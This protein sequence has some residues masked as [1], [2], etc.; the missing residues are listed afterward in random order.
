MTIGGHCHPKFERVREEFE[1]NFAERDELGASVCVIVDGEAVVDLWGGIADQVSGR[2][3]DSDTVQVICSSTKGATALCGNML[4]DRGQL[5]PDRPVADYWPQFAKNGKETIPVRQVFN[6]Q[7][8]VF[9]WAPT[10]PDGGVCDWNLVVQA[11]EDTAPFWSPGTRQGYHGLSLGYLVGELVRRI[12]GRSIGTFFRD[13]VA[14]P[15]GLDF[16]IGLPGEIEPRV[17]STVVVDLA[18]VS[19]L[20]KDIGDRAPLAGHLFGNDGGWMSS[21]DR[22]AFHA[23]E[24]PAA[25]GITNG[26]GLASMYAPLSRDGSQGDVRLVSSAALGRMRTAQSVSDVDAVV[27]AR[28]SYTMG[29]SKSWH[30]PGLEAGPSVIIG[31]DAFGAPGMGGQMGFAD[32]SY[33]LAFGYTANRHGFGTGLNA[34]GQSLIDATYQVLGSPTC[35]PGFW[36]RPDRPRLC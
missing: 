10:L 20:I 18:T 13:E 33:Q 16:W 32:P 31:E 5:D 34:R 25:G 3:W 8:G 22:P 11:L 23:A 6:H 17:A 27:G 29:F 15:L 30:N 2:S 24:L 7:S 35:E 28:T 36:V 12:D 14:E 4:I 19:G 21:V 9:H 26:R 1:R